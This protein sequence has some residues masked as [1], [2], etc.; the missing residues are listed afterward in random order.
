LSKQA[1]SGDINSAIHFDRLCSCE[2]IPHFALPLVSQDGISPISGFE[3]TPRE[4]FSTTAS[5][6]PADI[7]A[8][9]QKTRKLLEANRSKGTDK[10]RSHYDY[11]LRI[12]DNSIK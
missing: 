8:Y 3:Q 6:T 10:V 9:L 2:E 4:M 11:L 7:Y 1:I 5:L 12:I